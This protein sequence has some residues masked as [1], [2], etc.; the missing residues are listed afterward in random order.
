MTTRRVPIIP[1]VVVIAAVATM[2]ALGVWQLGRKDEKEALIARY[3]AAAEEPAVVPLPFAAEH[4]AFLFRRAGFTCAEVTGW[5]S[6]AGRNAEDQSGY[7]QVAT[8]R[9][10][11]WERYDTGGASAEVVAG[12]AEGPTSAE[13]A[14]GEV[15]GVIARGGDNG[16]RLVADRP[17]AGLQAN[18]TPDPRDLPN[19]HLAYAGQWFFFALTALVIYGLALRRRWRDRGQGDRG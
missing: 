17:L 10:A 15:S 18:A 19:N 11:E 9:V 16:W 3:L 5:N 13:W 7:V 6:I 8:C 4:D 1:T 14:G 12:W 2:V